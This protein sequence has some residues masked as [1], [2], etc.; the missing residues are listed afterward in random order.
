MV[1]MYPMR[2][3]CTPPFFLLIPMSFLT[4]PWAQSL[5]GELRPHGSPK[6]SFRPFKVVMQ[7]SPS[8]TEMV[9]CSDKAANCKPYHVGHH[10]VSLR[11]KSL[12]R[13]YPFELKF[14]RD[15]SRTADVR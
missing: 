15:T 14:I 9:V 1:R 3:P 13:L 10:K 4:H 2:G 11:N 7:R 8:V 12:H 5:R 6:S